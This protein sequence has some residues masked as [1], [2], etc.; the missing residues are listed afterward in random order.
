MPD[1]SR[2]ERY[3]EFY[4]FNATVDTV[5]LV[6]ALTLQRDLGL[7]MSTFGFYM[8]C[9]GVSVHLAVFGM[10]WLALGKHGHRWHWWLVSLVFLLATAGIA[11]LV[12]SAI[13]VGY[14]A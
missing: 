13:R 8:I 12:S 7:A 5:G 2:A 4:K 6:A 11:G 1:D 3:R 10:F 14:S 9:F